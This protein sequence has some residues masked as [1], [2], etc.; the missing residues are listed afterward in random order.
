[1]LVRF[2]PQSLYC[3]SLFRVLGVGV[4]EAVPGRYLRSAYRSCAYGNG[5]LALPVFS[6]EMLGKLVGTRGFEP[7]TPTP[8]DK[9]STCFCGFSLIK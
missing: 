8:P 4:R 6:T 1:M 7:P 3:S 2:P 5:Q 9:C